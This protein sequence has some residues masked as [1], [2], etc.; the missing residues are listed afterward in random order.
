MSNLAATDA[1]RP[2]EGFGR[3][4]RDIDMEK[5]GHQ[6]FNAHETG[7]DGETK[8]VES[9]N[10]QN[11]VQRVRAIT[12]IWST[13]TLITML[14]FIYLIEFVA[15]LQNAIDAALNP[16]ITS[17]FG[18]HGLL[19]VGSVMATALGGCLPLVIAKVIDI[20]GR[21]EGFFFM[22]LIVVAG[23]AMK[24]ACTNVQTYIA[25][26]VLYWAG[27]IGVLFVTDI[28]AA[29]CTSLTNRMIIF[30]LNGTPR[31]ASTFAG[32][33]IADLFYY[34]NSWR[35]AFGAFII[36]FV[37]CCAP[38]LVLMMFMYRKAR[39]AGLVKNVKSDRNVLQ[40]LQYYIIQF[41]IIGII[42]I[43]CAWSLFVL[44]FSLVAYA[45]QGWKTPYI[46]ACI[47]LG[48]CLFPCF[49]IWEA[50]FAPVQFLPWKYLKN[51]TIVGSCL[52]YCVMF[53]SVFCWNGYFYSYLLVVHR[54]S[55]PHAGYIL[56]AFSLT[57]STF[58]PLIAWWIHKSGNFKWT[59]YTGVP[60][61]LLGTALLIPFR[62]PSTN[63]GVLAFTQVLVGLGTAFFATC[64]QLA[65]MVPVTHQEIAVVNAVW[66]L[67]GSF[68]S[69]IGYAIAGGMWNNILP[70]Q[71]LMRLPEASKPDYMKIFGNITLQSS[72]LDGTPERDAV[73]G[74]YADVQRKMVITGACFVPLCLASIYIWKNINVK[75]LEEENGKQTKG[76]VF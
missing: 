26:H 69:S 43:M 40:S 5:N 63:P 6:A 36:I 7:S 30:T 19:N 46:I 29:D 71:M 2:V 33:A 1:V 14:V 24:A 44:P 70:G 59:A 3:P 48:I 42:L 65:V 53:L 72:F 55:I 45:P 60:I 27:H 9:E 64:A 11:G 23:M 32:P 10:F 39:K 18:T 34:H 35:W 38:A 73:V 49:Y 41:D 4:S 56:N 28:M 12:E 51:G 37:G 75:K 16:F 13:P 74:A 15:F 47:V 17:A 68:G 62:N 58:S 66:G 76:N 61:V 57:S 52:L 31:I 21:V 20:F 22:L 54:Q 67:F 8:S 50:K 25:G